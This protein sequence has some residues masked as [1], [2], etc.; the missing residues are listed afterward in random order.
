MNKEVDR[1]RWEMCRKCACKYPH[2]GARIGIL[3]AIIENRHQKWQNPISLH[4]NLHP[5]IYIPE[6]PALLC[7]RSRC[8]FAMEHL[9]LSQ[10]K[11]END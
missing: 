6:N 5:D 9:V 10:R 1:L 4:R 2:Q 8:S 3:K 11:P 7:S